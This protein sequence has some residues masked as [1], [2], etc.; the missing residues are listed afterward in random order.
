MDMSEL[1]DY[2]INYTLWLPYGKKKGAFSL[3]ARPEELSDEFIAE[4]L[5]AI[6]PSCANA[7]RGGYTISFSS[8]LPFESFTTD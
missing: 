3:S 2:N 6:D 5:V 8:T 1:K 7:E 4:Q